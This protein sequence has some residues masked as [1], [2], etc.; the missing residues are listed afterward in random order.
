[1]YPHDYSEYNFYCELMDLF[2]FFHIPSRHAKKAH[3][4]LLS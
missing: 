3:N 1:M 2:F 4:E